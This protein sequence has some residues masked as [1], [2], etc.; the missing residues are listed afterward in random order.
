VSGGALLYVV[1][2]AFVVWG[3]VVWLKVSRTEPIPVPV[4]AAEEVAG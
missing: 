2:G 3:F 4:P 1:Y